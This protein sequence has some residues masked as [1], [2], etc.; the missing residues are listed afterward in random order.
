M[1]IVERVDT[2]I[3]GFDKL[4]QGGFVKDSTN[5]IAG[6]AG[7]AKTTFCMQYLWNGLLKG[8]NGVYITLEQSPEDI[9]ADMLLFG[10]DFKKHIDQ[11]KLALY[12]TYPTSI[13]KLGESVFD[14]IKRV[15]AKRLVLD[16][17]SIASAG[18]EESADISKIRRDVFDMMN[19][20]KKVGVTSLLISE[21]PRAQKDA[22]SRFGFEEF[23]VD[24]IVLLQYFSIGGAM[25]SMQ[26]LKMRRTNHGKKI[27]PFDVTDKGIVIRN[28]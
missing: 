13:P 8:E 27:Y 15:N 4:V 21:I 12:S 23:V 14:I 18:W 24:S 3:P 7:T 5:L 28:I 11:K 26:I 17:L 2:G 25:R 9:L 22:L 20:L 1:P 10:W 16:S 19:M 6:G